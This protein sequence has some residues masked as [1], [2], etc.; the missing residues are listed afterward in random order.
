MLQNIVAKS[1]FEI[2]ENLSSNLQD[3]ES[4]CILL[5]VCPKANDYREESAP[6]KVNTPSS[7]EV[8]EI[9]I[10]LV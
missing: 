2:L 5:D 1:D 7:E 9:L 10:H 6:V 8:S 4:I 3:P